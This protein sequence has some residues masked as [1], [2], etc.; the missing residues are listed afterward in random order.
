MYIQTHTIVNNLIKIIFLL[1]LIVL[2]FV[3]IE[4]F[5]YSQTQ[6]ID[7]EQMYRKE[8]NSKYG[9]YAPPIPDTLWFADEKV[10]IEHFDIRESLDRE[11][12]INTYWQSQTV[13]LI[14]KANRYFPI[15]EPILAQNGV[16][17]DFKYVAVAE[18]GLSNAVSPAGA[19]GFWQFM[20][21]AGTQYGLE[22]NNEVDERYH[23]EKATHAA[24]RYLKDAY[25]KFG[26]WSLVA[27]SYNMGMAGVQGQLKSQKQETYYDLH[28]NEETARYVFRI[29]AFKLIFSDPKAY[30]FNI[31]QKDMYQP[32]ACKI[33]TT[34]S[35]ITDLIKFA[36]QQQTNYKLLK[37][38][39]PWLR[40]Q[41]LTNAR[42][43][44]YDILIPREGARIY[45]YIDT[46]EP[47]TLPIQPFDSL[48]ID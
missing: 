7:P 25:Q 2:F 21:S 17:D 48:K 32:I 40:T 35:S 28:L 14:K 31:R 27:A 42:K 1:L 33:I 24:C 41:S 10:P 29:L 3:V 6:V 43:K 45:N 13:L 16:P 4:I 30:G 9:I 18:S 8:F 19:R 37:Y 46:I 34:D 39:N 47:R 23:L 22:I 20:N 5:S 11:L 12:L 26:S 15:I 38:L 44:K 36:Q